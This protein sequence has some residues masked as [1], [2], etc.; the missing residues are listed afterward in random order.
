MTQQSKL[1]WFMGGVVVLLLVASLVGW[2]LHRRSRTGDAKDTIDNLNARIRAWWVMV[3]LL[4]LCLALGKTATVVLYAFASAFALREFITLTPTHRADHTSLV[5]C[6]YVLLPLQYWLIATGWYGLFSI[7]IPVYGFLP[8]PVLAALAGDT[9]AFLERVTKIQWG[10]M[11]TV[12]CISYAPAL[13]QLRIPGYD[14]QSMLLV[15]V[16][17]AY[18]ADQRRAP[19]RIWQVVRQTQDCAAP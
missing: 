8:L 4:G 9:D 18:R 6:F 12:Y 7:L 19:V 10:V 11:I 16:F 13:L 1:A 17:A 3:A 15:G 14:G 5:A 2:A